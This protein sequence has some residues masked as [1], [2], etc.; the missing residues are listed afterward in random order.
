MAQTTSKEQQTAALNTLINLS[1][2]I[3]RE[4][5]AQVQNSAN[6]LAVA[7]GLAVE[8]PPAEGSEETKG[9]DEAQEGKDEDV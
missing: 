7:L 9:A 2:Q 3:A 4:Q 6:L 1:L 8:A 5:Q